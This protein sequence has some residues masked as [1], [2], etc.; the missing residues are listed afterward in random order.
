M[1]KVGRTSGDREPKEESPESA[2]KGHGIKLQVA[3][4]KTEVRRAEGTAQRYKA[5]FTCMAPQLKSPASHPKQDNHDD[6]TILWIH[7][8]VSLKDI[9]VKY[10]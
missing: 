9:L 1:E 10:H 4:V 7:N 8:P 2:D 3:S 6:C 5:C